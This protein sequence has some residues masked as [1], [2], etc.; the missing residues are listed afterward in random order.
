MYTDMDQL[1]AG[2]I[3]SRP[4]QPVLKSER[5]DGYDL[6]FGTNVLGHAHFTLC[7]LPVLLEG[8]K[9]SKDGKARVV[10]VASSAMYSAKPEGITWETLTDTP[11]RKQTT[12]F[13]MYGQSKFVSA[14]S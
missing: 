10:N 5:T 9:T 8:A 1:T 6:Q 12:T 13:Y 3:L 4:P 2:R 7:L 14:S 11:E